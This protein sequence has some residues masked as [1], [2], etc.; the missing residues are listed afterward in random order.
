MLDALSGYLQLTEALFAGR[1]AV[2]KGWNF[3]PTLDSAWPV[4]QIVGAI[5]ARLPAFDFVVEPSK[6]H[7]ANLLTLDSGQA[8]RELGWKPQWGIETALEKTLAERPSSIALWVVARPELRSRPW[9]ELRLVV[10]LG[11]VLVSMNMAFYES[12]VR[13]PLG[14]AVTV[15]F[16]PSCRG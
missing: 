3:G 13:I 11:L 7:E 8:R 12:I 16:V 14:I 10:A 2:A 4:E 9:K 5:K 15:E 6:E 1:T